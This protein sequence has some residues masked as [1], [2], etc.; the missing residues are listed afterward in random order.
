MAGPRRGPCPPRSWPAPAGHR[1]DRSRAGRGAGRSPAAPSP[2][3]SGRGRAGPEPGSAKL[4]RSSVG[5]LRA[6]QA[7]ARPAGSA[8][9]ARQLEP[10]PRPPPRG[11][12][13]G[14]RVGVEA[15]PRVLQVD[16]QH[17]EAGEV[18]PA[19]AWSCGR[20]GSPRACRSRVDA[21]DDLLARRR[22][23]RRPCSGAKSRRRSMA[24]AAKHVD[25]VA[26]V[27]A[28]PKPHGTA[29]PSR[30]PRR[31][32]SPSAMTSRPRPRPSARLRA[33]AR[34]PRHA[35]GQGPSSARTTASARSAR[36]RRM[37][38][39]SRVGMH[40]VRQQ[41]HEQPA[42]GIDP[43]RGAGEAGVAEGARAR[44]GCPPRSS[45]APGMELRG[46]PT[47]PRCRSRGP[48]GPGHVRRVKRST[49]SRA[50][51][52]WCSKTPP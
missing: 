1:D 17:V 30:W 44:R 52:R 50:T 22:S 16:H 3:G 6:L 32:S 5:S 26:A 4:A 40:A 39:F 37:A 10:R 33:G 49:V 29:S 48:G 27:R 13:H 34:A 35:R 28:S 36:T 45:P 20:R 18:V 14:A 15:D 11:Q 46:P 8:G 19:P 38:S 41:D 25:G 47:S 43:E 23:P 42:V 9:R 21:V 2:R 24:A 51:I 12:E 7:L 31:A